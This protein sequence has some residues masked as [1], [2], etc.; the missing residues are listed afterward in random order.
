ME[1]NMKEKTEKFKFTKVQKIVLSIAVLGIVGT[2]I[3]GMYGQEVPIIKKDG[4]ITETTTEDGGKII[5]VKEVRVQPVEEEFPMNM[6][7]FQ[8]G[9]VIHQMS[10]QKIEAEEKWGFLPLTAERVNRLIEVVENGDY[11]N[12]DRYLSILNRWSKNDFTQVD[13][14]HNT[15][16]NLQGGNVGKATGILSYEEE[17]EFIEKYY[18]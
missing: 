9:Q 11:Q 4:T 5:E 18:E 16:W 8:V 13:E 2:I 3:Y 10:H 6:P 1:D 15:F 14:D 17:K 7:D 12:K